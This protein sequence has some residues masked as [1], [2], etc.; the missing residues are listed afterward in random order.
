MNGSASDSQILCFFAF[1]HIILQFGRVKAKN[2]EFSNK[3]VR[4]IVS[5]PPLF[6]SRSPM[7]FIYIFFVL[8]VAYFRRRHIF[9]TEK[10]HYIRDVFFVPLCVFLCLSNSVASLSSVV[11][12]WNFTNQRRTHANMSE[13]RK[14]ETREARFINA[15]TRNFFLASVHDVCRQ[16]FFESLSF[17]FSSLLSLF[18]RRSDIIFTLDVAQRI[19]WQIGMCFALT[20]LM[21]CRVSM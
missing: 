3:F 19:G 15:C 13:T 6:L 21:S 4:R 2:N 1:I 18:P 16:R 14:R 7:S 17:I 9:G 12:R 5:V 20:Y 10:H 8:F 11:R